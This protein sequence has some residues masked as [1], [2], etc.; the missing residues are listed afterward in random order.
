MRV[1]TEI[2]ARLFIFL[3]AWILRKNRTLCVWEYLR[4]DFDHRRISVFVDAS[5]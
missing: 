2:I 4:L 3:M 1:L 5:L